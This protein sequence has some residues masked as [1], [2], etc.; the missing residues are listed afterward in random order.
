V[1]TG[2]RTVFTVIKRV[3]SLLLALVLAASLIPAPVSATGN[4]VQE[5]EQQIRATYRAALRGSG[6]YSFNGYCGSLVNWQTCI[7]GIDQY[8]HGCDGKDEYDHYVRQGVTCGGYKVRAYPAGQYTL[9]SALKTITNNGTMDAYNILVGFQRTNTR[10]GSIYGHAL[11][12]HA[13]LDGVVYFTECFNVS[14]NGKFWQEG[15]PVHCTIDEFSAYYDRWTVFEGVVYFGVKSYADV[16]SEAPAGM[17]AMA[18]RELTVYEE[19]WD[20]EVYEADPTGGKIQKGRMVSV[21]TLLVTPG[22]D[23]WYRLSNGGYV[24]AEYLL[25]IADDPNDITIFDLKVPSALRRGVGWAL[26]GKINASGSVLRSVEVIV[27]EPAAGIEE[28]VFQG[29]LEAE[30]S[31]LDLSI[32]AMDRQMVFRKLDAGTYRIAIRV[33]ADSY[34]LQ[35]GEMVCHNQF[36]T[37]HD[38]QFQIIT[39][40]RHYVQVTYDSNGGDSTLDAETIPK[41]D[42]L[43]AL[44]TASRR[45]Y[46]FAGWALDHNGTRMVSE[47]TVLEE[48]TVLYAQWERGGRISGWQEIGGVWRY[49]EDGKAVEGWV[50]FGG[51]TFWQE[52]GKPVKGWQTVMGLERYFN[53]AGALMTGWQ[54][55]NGR[56]FY[57]NSDG[58][59]TVGWYYEDGGRYYFGENGARQTGWIFDGG[60]GYYLYQQGTVAAGD[61]VIEGA[62]C[63]FDDNGVL[64]FAQRITEGGGYYVVYDRQSADTNMVTLENLLLG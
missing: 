10:E 48:D 23:Y 8:V 25:R 64:E 6:R 24:Q 3:I 16:C 53:P 17:T 49:F 18:T 50:K 44:P 21:T 46:T 62:R 13:I 55:I 41:G 45:G 58:C 39:D 4:R 61:C 34:Y 36:L 15:D 1:F 30:G 42:A 29:F 63:K 60:K 28:P 31:S 9:N 19:P 33:E 14:L 5:I 27:Y 20:P 11:L 32:K 59:K 51:V 43:G 57:L 37:L 26:R 2:E 47:S 56:E 54:S 38:S 35:D 22:G 52:N 7:L 12:I 40:W